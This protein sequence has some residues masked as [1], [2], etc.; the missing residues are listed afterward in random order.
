M[1]GR[2]PPSGGDHAGPAQTDA[3]VAEAVSEGPDSTRR[4][5]LAE[6]IDAQEAE[7]AR[8]ARDLHDD[9]GQAL[10]SVLLGIGL[11]GRALGTEPRIDEARDRVEDLRDVVADALDR[12]RQLAFDLRPTVLD[13]IGLVPT[14]ERL[15][16]DLAGRTGV[17]VEIADELPDERLAPHVETVLYRVV[18]EALTNV[19]RHAQ[20]STAHVA[21]VRRGDNVRAV[22]S[23]DGRGFDVIDET[24]NVGI[25]GMTERARLVGG[26]LDIAS[27][28]GA[29]TTVTLE[30]PL[31]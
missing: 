23:D 19:V 29:G 20:A 24:R 27:A 21:L 14:L 17:V 6:I 30:V 13:D 16:D 25:D 11:I 8:I 4:E 3:A 7:R 1:S 9:V 2:V 28:D 10:T 15:A 18:Q 12:T 31:D 26:H 22:I 5:V